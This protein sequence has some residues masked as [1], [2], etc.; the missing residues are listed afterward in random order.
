[1]ATSQ[2][3]WPAIPSS[4]D[5][6]LIAIPRIAGRVCKGDVEWVFRDF[7]DKFDRQVEDV[8]DKSREN[9]W[10]YAYRE[11]RGD[12]TDLSNHS[13]GTALDLNAD[14]HPLGKVGTFT[15]EQVRKITILLAYYK[16]AIRWGG[17]YPG[18]KD[19]M[20]FEINVSP[21]ELEKIV[22]VLKVLDLESTGTV[23]T[24][25]VVIIAPL[26]KPKK[27]TAEN[28]R[29]QRI[30]RKLNLYSGVID[31]IS[32]PMQTAAIKKYQSR[33]RVPFKLVS[34]GNWGK[35]T[36]DHYQWVANLQKAMNKWRST[37]G[38]DLAV[39]GDYGVV[40]KARILDLMRRNKGE[41]YKGLI[42]GKPGSVFCKML[43]IPTH[44]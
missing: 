20:H 28:E 41:A 29:I 34:D 22:A 4:T 30:L 33:Q 44:P 12:S 1:M 42:D 25:P 9:D 13:S 11:I 40:T 43:G 10:G 16:G 17:N 21:A 15:A 26:P 19:E 38:V 18:R 35:L 36:E 27:G 39:D 31:G 24:K 32:G 23:P 14:L 8:D 5:D 6:R 2:N 3:G 37:S 7:V